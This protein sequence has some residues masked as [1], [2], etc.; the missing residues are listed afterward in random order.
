MLKFGQ[1]VEKMRVDCGQRFVPDT[2]GVE[3]IVVVALVD[4]GDTECGFWYT[5]P[6]SLVS[7]EFA[8]SIFA[9]K[10]KMARR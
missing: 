9:W 5:I 10:V 4:S 7:E 3:M 2:L 6:Y 1:T 8:A